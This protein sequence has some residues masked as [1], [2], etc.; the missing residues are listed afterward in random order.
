[1]RLTFYLLLLAAPST[2]QNYKS[3]LLDAARLAAR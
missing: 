3:E 2:A 1:M